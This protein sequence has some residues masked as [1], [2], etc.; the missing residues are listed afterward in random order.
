MFEKH[1]ENTLQIYLYI[2]HMWFK[3]LEERRILEQGMLPVIVV[4]D[5]CVLVWIA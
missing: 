4:P 3:C 5:P 2:S 1:V